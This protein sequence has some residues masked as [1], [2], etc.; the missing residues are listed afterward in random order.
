MKKKC[1]KDIN[2][3]IIETGDSLKAIAGN[4]ENLLCLQAFVKCRAFVVWLK[5]EF[6]GIQFLATE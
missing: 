1:L 2:Q 4:S 3:E 6:K 5:D